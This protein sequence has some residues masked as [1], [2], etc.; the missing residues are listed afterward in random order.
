MGHH[1]YEAVYAQAFA[2]TEGAPLD[3]TNAYQVL[4]P[5]P[6]PV[7]A[8]WSITLYDIPRY[9][10]VDTPMPPPDPGGSQGQVAPRTDGSVPAGVPALQPPSCVDAGYAFPPVQ[11]IPHL[12]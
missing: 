8:F 9:Y 4:F 6:P 12:P 2:Y 5:E 7:E 11:L 1:A 3:G 10:L